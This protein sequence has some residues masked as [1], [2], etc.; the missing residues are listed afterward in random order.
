[1]S[2]TRSE[3]GGVLLAVAAGVPVLVFRFG[4]GY[5][6]FLGRR[7]RGVRTFRDAL[8][9]GGMPPTM[10]SRLAEAYHEAGSLPRI[11]RTVRGKGALRRER[12]RRRSRVSG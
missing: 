12:S 1:M 3:V 7:R 5:L 2:T 6:R 11:L 8:L 4:A 9:A 10:A